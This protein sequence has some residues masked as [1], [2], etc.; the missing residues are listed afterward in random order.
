[1]TQSIPVTPSKL[2]NQKVI[3][4][5]EFLS[6]KHNKKVFATLVNEIGGDGRIL[7]RP[8]GTEN[9]IRVLIEHHDVDKID[10]LEMYFYDNIK[11]K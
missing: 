7:I 3:N 1:M 9:L 10:E 6:D 2:F 4:K 5:T 11:Q 8:S